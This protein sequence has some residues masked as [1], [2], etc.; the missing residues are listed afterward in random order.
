MTN[1]QLLSLLQS[2][3]L[4]AADALTKLK[5]EA[6]LSGR[7]VEEVLH[8]GRL[9]DD[10][11]LAEL[12]AANLKIPYQKLDMEALTPEVAV[13]VP[14]ETVRSYGIVPI[15][16]QDGTLVAGML[17][18]DDPK[19]QEALKFIARRERLS[20]GVYLISYGDWQNALGKYS[21]YKNSVAQAVKS[22][23]LKGSGRAGGVELE[24]A[25]ADEDAP[26]VRI[27][28]DTLRE[29]VQSGA[30][31]V[32]IEPQQNYLRVRFRI[33]G[34]LEEKASLPAELSQPVVSRVKVMSNLRIDETRIPQD[35]RFH[36]KISDRDID[37]RVSTFPTPLGEKVAIRVLDPQTGLKTLDDLGLSGN[38]LK[39]VKT[40]IAKP[41]GMVL[42]SG[43]TGSGKTTTLYAILQ[44]LNSEK[45][46]IVSLEDP[47]EYFV[48][49][50]NQSQ[51]RPEIKYD[52]ASGLREILRQDPD[53]IMV[54]EIRDNETA[55]LAIH[56]SLT[57]HIVLST[58][59]TNNALGVLPRL[60]DMDVEPFILPEAVNLMISQRLISKLCGSCRAAEDAPPALQEEIKKALE[61]VPPEV[62][63]RY[64]PPYKVYHAKGCNVCSGK[65]TTGRV[66]I[67][68]VL[69]MT[70]ELA[71]IVNSDLTGSKMLAEA[72][73][74]GMV[75]MREDGVVK[76]LDGLVAIEEVLRETAE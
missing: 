57:G 30:S 8:E 37:F 65:G 27:V 52:F 36:A 33:G 59:H 75:T 41:Y 55:G 7:S 22:L 72:K 38:N 56:A 46:N 54:G 29:A 69:Q 66:A 73:R 6:S 61:G 47:V 43:P 62:R 50:V 24:K 60:I 18:P 3:N 28:A 12:K 13:L 2:E 64:K 39:T 16:R 44:L 10:A 45:V 49:G 51:V 4:L 15:A 9:V 76:A 63:S 68:E 70:R 74:Q 20:L 67:F 21:P 34:D 17:N 53:V 23:N 32:H 35:G 1:D 71:D 11:R 14:E 48:S 25:A 19:A 58:I 42:I 5:R 31:D 40:G 26:V